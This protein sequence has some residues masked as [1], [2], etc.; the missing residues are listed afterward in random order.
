[1]GDIKKNGTVK[2]NQLFETYKKRL[3]APQKT[4]IKTLQEIIRDLLGF[5]IEKDHCSY[6][7]F[8]KTLTLNISGT[9]KTEILIRKEEILNHLKGRLGQKSAPKEII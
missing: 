4:V 7:V 8:N 2:I 3:Q 5:E 9:K 6:N 1:M